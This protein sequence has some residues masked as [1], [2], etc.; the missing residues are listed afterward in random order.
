M[1]SPAVVDPALPAQAVS[2]PAQAR[3]A[4]ARRS[5]VPAGLDAEDHDR[6][7]GAKSRP[8]RHFSAAAGH[9][10][11]RVHNR[12]FRIAYLRRKAEPER[13]PRIA[14]RLSKSIGA[15]LRA[16]TASMRDRPG[17]ATQH[18]ETAYRAAHGSRALICTP[19]SASTT[20]KLSIPPTP[21]ASATG[22]LPANAPP[23][24]APPA[25]S[26]APG[27]L[28]SERDRARDAENCK[29]PFHHLR[30]WLHRV[31][32]RLRP[33]RTSRMAKRL[34]RAVGTPLR[35]KRAAT[36]NPSRRSRRGRKAAPRRGTRPSASTLSPAQ[37][38]K[39]SRNTSAV[40]L[41]AATIAQYPAAMKKP[42]SR[43]R[44][45]KRKNSGRSSRKA[46][47]TNAS[48]RTARVPMPSL[49][50]ASDTLT[51]GAA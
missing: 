7:D 39:R 44:F 25:G 36:Y 38:E 30:E 14:S 42:V 12:G 13:A 8:Q 37:N 29:Q 35:K 18:L 9:E 46:L 26:S 2:P 41:A 31:V 23:T 11:A 17:N 19:A 50:A 49:G 34:Q 10:H 47:P 15:R 5:C 6:Q 20:A 16:A 22:R 1:T 33:R 51:F 4:R 32:R 45:E 27:S 43:R 24:C 40:V 21:I 28:P 3:T 48:A